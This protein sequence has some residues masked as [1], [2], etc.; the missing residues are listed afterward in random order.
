MK[1]GIVVLV[2]ACL[3]YGMGG[4]DRIDSIVTQ[5]RN[6]RDK[7]I[8]GFI[9]QQQK[10]Q[11]LMA[12]EELF[13]EVDE[14]PDAKKVEP[15][16]EEPPKELY[17]FS[18]YDWVE[19]GPYVPYDKYIEYVEKKNEEIKE[20]GIQIDRLT[21]ALGYIADNAT[22]QKKMMELLTKFLE[23]LTP[24]LLAIG[25]MMGWNK[26]KEQK[27]KKAGEN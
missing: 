3:V 13:D 27:R 10:Q 11:P 15:P 16:T 8:K 17:R 5:S 14:L 4:M 7:G 21:T 1:T 6:L 25:G 19:G 20:I 24:L 12:P 18:R 23:V 2:I 9:I 22:T 26:V